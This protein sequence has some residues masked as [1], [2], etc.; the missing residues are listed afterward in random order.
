MDWIS[1]DFIR[2]NINFPALIRALKLAFLKNNIQSPSKLAYSY[3]SQLRKDENTMLIMPAW[4]NKRFFGAKL[5]T[6]TPS[7]KSTKTP[8]LNGIYILFD[9]HNGLPI[10]TMD[11]KLITN[12]RTAAT[13][14]LA[15]KLLSKSKSSSVLI[16]GNGS[17]SPF[18]IEAYACLEHI[19]IIYLWGRNFEKSK[20]VISELNFSN[21]KEIT[22][23][24]TYKDLVASVDI[25]SCITSRNQP[26]I[27]IEDI[28]N[29]HHFDLAGSYTESMQEVSTDIVQN[30]FVFTDN[31]NITLEHAGELVKAF[32]E[33]K[34][35]KSTVKGDMNYLFQNDSIRRISDNENT[36][37]KSTG[38]ALEDLV[39]ASLIYKKSI[40]TGINL[41]KNG[42]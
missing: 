5:I 8:Y 15:S 21:S 37:F 3:K 32:S 39:I 35:K 6:A 19:D 20:K 17:L 31:L 30:C 42:I 22:A 36:M 11:A 2:E 25:I 14:V 34:L 40:K 13:S 18:F 12:M 27:E 28:S 10:A 33:E 4:D 38:M 16:L 9:A 41:P 7:N 23:I 29:G 24:E 26:L 1:E